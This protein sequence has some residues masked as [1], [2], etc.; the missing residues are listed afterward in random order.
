MRENHQ[1]RT[2]FKEIGRK[3][4][5]EYKKTH[6]GMKENCHWHEFSSSPSLSHVQS[7]ALLPKLVTQSTLVHEDQTEETDECF[8]LW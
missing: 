8:I 4:M 2:I 7:L 5:E 1:W 3:F 6:G